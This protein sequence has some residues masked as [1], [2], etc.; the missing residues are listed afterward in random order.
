M[1]ARKPPYS[2]DEL[3]SFV[4]RMANDNWKP[5]EISLSDLTD[6]TAKLIRDAA[7]GQSSGLPYHI[8]LM[9]LQRELSV[10]LKVMKSSN[11]L[12]GSTEGD[13]SCAGDMTFANASAIS[14]GGRS[15]ISASVMTAT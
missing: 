13:S 8:Q 5:L 7:M 10:L 3:R 14:A 1:S 4:D 2:I 11:G 6:R 9:D 15:D 12:A